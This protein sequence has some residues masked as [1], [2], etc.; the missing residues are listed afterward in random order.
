VLVQ[1]PPSPVADGIFK[2]PQPAAAQHGLGSTLEGPEL[3]DR[4]LRADAGNGAAPVPADANLRV[5]CWTWRPAAWCATRLDWL[6]RG[7][8]FPLVPFV[9]RRDVE[10]SA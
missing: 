5:A 2:E 6:C 7:R 9:G 3:K 4:T 8:S 1:A 10:A